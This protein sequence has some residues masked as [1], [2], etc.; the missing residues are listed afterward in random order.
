[1][2]Q[3]ILPK[4]R[5]HGGPFVFDNHLNAQQISVIAPC[6]EAACF[7]LAKTTAP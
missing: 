4:A 3:N 2:A 7:A 5:R 1:L 6:C